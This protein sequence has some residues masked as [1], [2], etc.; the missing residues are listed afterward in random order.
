M[1]LAKETG[2]VTKAK[3]AELCN[4]SAGAVSHW[5]KDGKLTPPALTGTGRRAKINVELAIKQ[6]GDVLDFGQ[7]M[8]QSTQIEVPTDFVKQSSNV[9]ESDD[10][11]SIENKASPVQVQPSILDKGL[12]SDSARYTK[13]KAERLELDVRERRRKE[14]EKSGAWLITSDAKKEWAEELS[15]LIGSFETF[16][17]ALSEEVAAE[18]GGDAKQHTIF[19]REKFRGFRERYSREAREK[20]LDEPKYLDDKEYYE[21]GE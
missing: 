17:T 4:R 19:I 13:A 3:F 2:V 18:F 16:L 15:N 7:Q 9:S 12:N 20:Q 14:L 5:I 10:L 21:Q 1:Q 6:L 11:F 8:A